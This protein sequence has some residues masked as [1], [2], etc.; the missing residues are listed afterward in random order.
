P[1]QEG[2]Q[3]F[4]RMEDL[5]GPDR[6]SEALRG[7]VREMILTL[8][9]AELAEVLVALPYQRHSDRRGYRNGRRERSI[10]TG[11][12]TTVIELPRARLREGGEEKEWQSVL[13]ERYQRRTRSVTVLFWDVISVERTG[14]AYGERFP[15]FCVVRRFPRVR[16]RGLWGVFKL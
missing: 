10:S 9:E 11:L 2:T 5:F 6:L 14:G 7:K 15:R 4:G 16:S 1:M 12:G 3:C 8:A 13:I